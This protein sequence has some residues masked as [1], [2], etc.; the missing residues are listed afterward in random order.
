MTTYHNE[1]LKR[2]ISESLREKQGSYA[3]QELFQRFPTTDEL[4]DV[5][6]QQL[7]TIKGIGIGKARQ[8]TSLL[9]L[10]KALTIPSITQQSIR[11]P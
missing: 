1:E 6:D 5:S 10:A 9:K 3:I 4:M 8:I 7:V 11:I 2:L